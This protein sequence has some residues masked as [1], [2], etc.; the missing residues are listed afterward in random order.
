MPSVDIGL[1][2]IRK[3][4]D[5]TCLNNRALLKMFLELDPGST[6]M[7]LEL[8]PGSTWIS[9]ASINGALLKMFLELEP[10]FTIIRVSNLPILLFRFI[11]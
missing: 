7:F 10:K 8:E 5:F 3:H 4:M 1:A 11:F 2:L 9:H 6:K